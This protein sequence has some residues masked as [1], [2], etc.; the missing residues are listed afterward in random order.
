MLWPYLP[1]VGSWP[2]VHNSLQMGR[3][4]RDHGRVLKILLCT[5]VVIAQ[6][7]DSCLL[8][9]NLSSS[10]RRK[11]VLLAHNNV[12]QRNDADAYLLSG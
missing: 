10:V 4:I 12:I 1:E 2:A 8:K 9:R 5:V 7:A 11:Y 6:N 3:A